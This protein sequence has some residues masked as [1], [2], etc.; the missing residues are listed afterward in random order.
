MRTGLTAFYVF[1]VNALTLMPNIG[2]SGEF[3][4]DNKQFGEPFSDTGDGLLCT[5]LARKFTIAM[6]LSDFHIHIPASRNYFL[7]KL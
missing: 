6:L 3:F 5:M 4:K 1:Q 7:E 2:V